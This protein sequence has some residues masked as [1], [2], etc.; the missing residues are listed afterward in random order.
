MR[1]DWEVV[2]GRVL[3]FLAAFARTHPELELDNARVAVATASLGGY[4]TLR[5]TANPRVGAYVLLDPLYS[6]WDFATAHASPA[7]LGAWSAAGSA[8]GLSMRP[9]APG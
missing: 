4:F 6:F 9:S 3:D 1:P 5:A 8:T 7:P 2:A